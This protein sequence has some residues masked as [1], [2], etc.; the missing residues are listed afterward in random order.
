VLVPRC[1]FASCHAVPTVAAGLDLTAEHACGL[2][3][4]QPSCL[5]PDRK[6]IVPGKP[7]DS[8][9]FHKILGQGLSQTPTGT[10]A[11]TNLLM[12]LGGSQ[13]PDGEL[14]LVRDWIAAGAECMAKPGNP[15]DD[16][17]AI[18]TIVSDHPMPVAGDTIKFTVTLDKPAPAAGQ[19]IALSIDSNVTSPPI[20][21]PVQVVVTAN[22]KSA[23]FQGYAIRPA[24]RLTVRATT[25]K[26]S[27]QL[28]VRIGGLEVVEVLTDPVGEDDKLQW[29]KLHNKSLVSIDLS[30]F[31]LKAGE[32]SYGMT[33]LALTGM[34]EP[35]E[36]AVVGGP[37]SSNINGTPVFTP[38]TGSDFVPNLPHPRTG[39]S[40][41][42]IF[43]SNTAPVDGIP[44]PVDTM[45]I[46]ANNSARLLGPDGEI[47]PPFCGTPVPGMSARRT[48][49]DACLESPMQPNSCP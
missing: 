45:I 18:A 28:V 5:F 22:M 24:S 33:S 35:G 39:T 31:T 20:S 10:C 46:G 19:M 17:P 37:V 36:C 16:A 6:R 48:N 14:S 1:T 12:P 11:T 15:D 21:A 4:D 29:I 34:L 7:N 43:D 40:G 32:S 47:P 13:I 44:T 49:F 30:Q 27:K 23:E 42:A 25:S 2:L 41:F 3:V 9:L 8:F 26:S 38:P